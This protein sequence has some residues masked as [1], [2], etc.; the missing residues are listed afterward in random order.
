MLSEAAQKQWDEIRA[1]RKPERPLDIDR[2]EWEAE[3]AAEPLPEGTSI[4]AATMGGVPSEWITNGA[5]DAAVTI[6]LL[7]GGGYRA[8]SLVTHRGFASRLSRLTGHRVLLPD[9]R[10]APDHPYPA[11]PDDAEAVYRALVAQGAAPHSIVLVGDSAG[12]GLAI[13]LMLMLKARGRAQPVGAVLLSP[14]TDLQCA[15]PSYQAN[16]EADPGMSR[17]GLLSAADDY[18]GTLPADHP[19][20]SPIHADLSGL[21]PMLVA[22]GG[23][24]IMLSD[25]TVFAER[26]A[27]AGCDVTLDIADGMWHVY[28]SAPDALPEVVESHARIK[29]FVA[30]VTARA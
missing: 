1:N 13:T 2:A 23:G 29:G 14:W 28:Q 26:A 21:P 8:G 10:L 6:L 18:R 30:R 16:I 11:A 19:M 5:V 7:H 22:A 27:A 4:T 17:D 15:G 3:A 20:L 9:Y 25:S 12:G 24:E